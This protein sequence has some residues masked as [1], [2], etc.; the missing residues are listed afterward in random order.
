MGRVQVCPIFSRHG[1]E[2]DEEVDCE[3][4][5]SQLA[6][7]RADQERLP[8]G[9]YSASP[10]LAEGRLYV[11]NEDGLASVVE[12]ADGFEIL[13]TNDM[14]AYTLSSMAMSD[15]QIFLRTAEALYC[16]GG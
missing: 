13:A 15:G 12:V 6:D 16:I 8:P 2:G 11:I 5:N 9:T 3:R 14:G 10:V 7:D 4:G 1:R